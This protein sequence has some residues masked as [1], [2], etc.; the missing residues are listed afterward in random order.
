MTTTHNRPPQNDEIDLKKYLYLFLEYWYL[1]LLITFVTV[2]IAWFINSNQVREYKVAAS[3]LIE[4]EKSQVNPWGTGTGGAD[5]T[6]G[7]GLF[8]SMKNLQNQ[9][10]ILQSY[11][12]VMRTIKALDFEVT[13][14][15]DELIRDKEVYHASPYIIEFDRSRPQLLGVTFT[16]D[17]DDN[18]RMI[19]RGRATGDRVETYNYS[20][21]EI[22]PADGFEEF[23]REI[24]PGTMIANDNFAFIVRENPEI[25]FSGDSN[26]WYFRFNSYDGLVE[27]WRKRMTLEPMDREASMVEL[28]IETDCPG[29]AK[30][31]LDTH[32]EMYLQRTLERKNQFASN[33]IEFID[34]QLTAISDSLGVTEMEL[35]DYRKA[36]EVVDLS[37]QAQQLFE[38]ARELETRKADISIQADYFSYL[39]TYLE[40]EREAGDLLAP[41]VMGIEDPLLNSLVL[42]LNEMA[43][44]KIAL[45]GSGEGV[46]PYTRTIDAQI[47]SAREALLESARNLANSNELAMSDINARLSSLMAEVR[48]LPETERE[49]FG[50]ERRFK[51]NDYIYTYLLQRRA[52]A[53]IAKASN[54]PDN[55]IIDLARIIGEPIR[56]KGSMN[57]LIG[58]LLGLGI[59]GIGLILFEAFNNRVTTEDDIKRITD[60]PVA[61]H[62]IHSEFSFQEVVLRNPQSHLAESFRSLRTRLQFFTKDKQ[63]PVILITSTMPAEGKT[64]S[65]INLASAYSIAGKKTV[66]VG[67]DL[68][69][70]KIYEDF[71]LDNGRGVSTFLIGRDTIEGIINETEF[72][73]LS[74]IAAGPIPPNP[75]ELS[76]SER[77]GELFRELKKRFDYIIVDS[78]PIGT[79]S[80]TYALANIA[81]ATILLVRH[82]RTVKGM[83]R[84]TI[85][86][87]RFNGLNNLSLLMNDI[88]ESRA[89]YG[90]TYSYRYGY[91]SS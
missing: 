34:R 91:Y 62:I 46:N 84:N 39:T 75:A 2:G 17:K 6:S 52:E 72:D 33:T 67:F 15:K 3:L 7:F 5:V 41:S 45:Q 19:L 1:F 24:T 83:L 48:T 57:Y 90:Y 8:P 35:Q 69:K 79:V 16:V 42:E 37:F 31:F 14:L 10:L 18:G 56:P 29:K 51:L 74:I 71:G 55:E 78:A 25:P 86:D 60:L 82:N 26:S 20:T 44:Q 87:A 40:K 32:L 11:S 53:Q 58:L 23:E 68:R 76:D 89:L 81:D 4:D 77:T 63:N 88:N 9:T 80:D 64:F 70:P 38:Q 27:Q 85:N 21:G 13:Y 59:P 30:A 50:I 49:L 47:K 54:A 12:Q 43:A 61:G 66:L 22:T 36:N 65:A 28:S 73:N